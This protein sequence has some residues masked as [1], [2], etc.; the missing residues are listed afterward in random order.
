[1]SA[2]NLEKV[3]YPPEPDIKYLRTEVTIADNSLGEPQINVHL[4]FY[5]IDG[6]GD[7]GLTQSDI[8]PPYNAN[9]FPTFYGIKNGIRKVD[10]TF[11][12]DEYRIPWVGDLGQDAA[13]K[14]E[15][16]IDFEYPY[17]DQFP[18]PYDSIM[19]SFYMVDRALN[20]SN[21]AWT[22]TIIIEK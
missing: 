10:T 9:F 15:V 5:L 17:N 20:K 18:F 3:D 12:A 21:I 13:L 16:S 1:M 19:Y 8:D 11:I 22:D 7:V 14:A 4:V 6:D 2:C